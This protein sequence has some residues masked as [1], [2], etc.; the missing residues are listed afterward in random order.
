[1]KGVLCQLRHLYIE[2]LPVGASKG[3][4]IRKLCKLKTSQSTHTIAIG[5]YYNDAELLESGGFAVTVAEAPQEIKAPVRPGGGPLHG[6]SCRR[7]DRIS[8]G[9]VR[10]L[11]QKK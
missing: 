10:P 9:T 11:D 8:G 3:D 7:F 6:R 5:D 4:A 2:M 1:M